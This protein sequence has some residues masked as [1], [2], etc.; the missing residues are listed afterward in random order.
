M[1][2]L[3]VTIKIIGFK[4]NTKPMHLSNCLVNP[5]ASHS[6]SYYAVILLSPGDHRVYFPP[7]NLCGCV[8]RSSMCT[9]CGCISVWCVLVA[10]CACVRSWSCFVWV[11]KVLCTWLV[12]RSPPLWPW[13]TCV[14]LP[15]LSLTHKSVTCTLTA[16]HFNAHHSHYYVRDDL[17]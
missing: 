1:C 12:A 9:A 13:I 14:C 4:F 11:C 10:V 6:C 5:P 7:C 8:I 3:F 15:S 17:R 16:S 2:R